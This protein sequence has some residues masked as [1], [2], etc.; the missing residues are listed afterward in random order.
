LR[1]SRAIGKL[2]KALYKMAK[3]RAQENPKKD[4][5]D[6]ASSKYLDAFYRRGAVIIG[7]TLVAVWHRLEEHLKL[8]Q[9]L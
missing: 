8:T 7:K 3:E 6:K 4:F 9:M 2:K 5:G 1:K